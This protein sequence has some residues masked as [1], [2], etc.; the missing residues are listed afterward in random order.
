MSEFTGERVV[1]GQVEPDLWNEHVARYA[2]ASR[3]AAHKR[4]LDVGCGTGYGSLE[5]AHVARSV[6][7]VD[8]AH[9]SLPRDKGMFVAARGEALPFASHSFD[10]VVAFEVIEHV[11]AWEELL[12]EARRLLAPGGQFIVSTPNRLYYAESRKLHG[13]NP[14]HVHE[15]D[16]DEFRAALAEH[17]PSVSLYLQN[18]VQGI[19]FQPASGAAGPAQLSVERSDV[20]A[21]ASHFFLAVCA[22]SAQTGAP[23]WVYL[24]ST[25]NLLREREQHIEL[26]EGELRQKD[27]WLEKAKSEHAALVEMHAAQTAELVERAEWAEKINKALKEAQQRIAGLQDEL[28]AEHNAA[29]TSHEVRRRF[30][31]NR[32]FW[33]V[34]IPSRRLRARLSCGC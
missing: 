21:E 14:Y 31:S 22:A 25:A 16:Y 2:F 19:A 4:V 6:V 15:F 33:R 28:V 5:L 13:P 34:L 17:F 12:R 18:H 20:T 23:T 9:A 24:P 7:A 11:A 3:L 10:L 1:A 8:V 27:A 26:L 32:A 29:H 30:A